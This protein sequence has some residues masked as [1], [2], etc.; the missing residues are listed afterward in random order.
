MT[1]NITIRDVLLFLTSAVLYGLIE[2]THVR[3]GEP[4]LFHFFIANY[5]LP[6]AGIMVILAI[7]LNRLQ[8]IPLWVLI[9][10]MCFWIF[11]GQELVKS[12][13]ISIGLSGMTVAGL[14]LP[15]TYVGLLGLWGIF[16][17]IRWSYGIAK[18]KFDV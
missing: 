17:F 5:H 7:G 12:S 6:M 11:S 8:D 4:T 14:Y 1:R 9:E 13:W 3:F 10:D 18:I 15:W 16:V 2:A